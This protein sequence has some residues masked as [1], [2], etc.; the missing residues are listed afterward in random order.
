[1][2][3]TPQDPL[4]RYTRK[5]GF[6]PN[7]ERIVETLV[8]L[9]DKHPNLSQYQIVK[10][11]FLADRSHMNEVGRPITYDNYVAMEKG[12]VPSL[13]YDLLK[14]SSGVSLFR[15]I[16]HSEPPWSATRAGDASRFRASRKPRKEYL[17]RTD[18][19]SLDEALG[20]VLKMNKVDMD[21]LLH[22]DASYKEAR[23]KRGGNNAPEM[24]AIY[25]LADRDE[26]LIENLVYASRN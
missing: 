2:R 13:I 10:T 6:C 21:H 12:P 3:V 14:P 8:Y 26:E 7:K 24:N 17:S 15:G 11:V 9:M 25:L 20:M 22:S 4:K 19:R 18:I 16:Y 23:S 1:M 5:D